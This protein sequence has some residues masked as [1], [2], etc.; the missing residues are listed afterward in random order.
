[1][2]LHYIKNSVE[3][4]QLPIVPSEYH[5]KSGKNSNSITL[6]GFGEISDS[7]TPTLKTWSISAM[8]PKKQ[9]SMCTCTIKSNPFDYVALVEKLKKDNI[10]CTYVITKTNINIR[11]TIEEFEYYEQDG[12]GDVYYTISFKEH[13]EIKLSNLSNANITSGVLYFN[14]DYTLDSTKDNKVIIKEG[15]TLIKIAKSYYGDSSK[16]EDIMIKNGL[17]NPNDITVGQ[18]LTI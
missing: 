5:M 3:N 18:V 10:V 1:M 4:I 17:S 8:F 6:L 15:D 12:S 11:C 7:G 14:S 2:K 9:Y 13:K 16:Y